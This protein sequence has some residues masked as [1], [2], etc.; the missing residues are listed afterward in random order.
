MQDKFERSFVFRFLNWICPEHLVEEIE[1]D[2]IQKFNSDVEKFD[3]KRA[4]RRL[5]WNV[6]RFC[7]LGIVLRS[8]L[9]LDVNHLYMI[10]IYIILV[11]RHLIRNKV[12]SLVNL[13]GLSVSMAVCILILQYVRFEVSYDDFHRQ[14]ENIY[15]VA[16]KVTLQG[17]VINHETNTYEGIS[18]ALVQDFPEVKAATSIRSFNS[19]GT[20]IRYE[21]DDKKLVPLQSFK[22]FDVDSTFFAVFSFQL[23]EGN[24][25]TVLRDPY[26]AVISEA[27]SNQ[28]FSGNAVGQVLEVYD[29]IETTRYKITGVLKDVP[30]NSHFKFDLLTRSQPRDKNFWNGD[31]GFWEWGGHSYILLTDQSNR[32]ALESKLAK[33]ALSK[34]ELKN[35]KDD[36]GQVSTFELQP[37]LDIHLFSHL[38]EELEANGSGVFVYSLVVLAFMIIIIAWVNYINL[39]T[40]VSQEKIRSIGVRKVVGASKSGLM[41]QVL[42]EA[43]VFNV[44]SVAIAIVLVHLLLPFFSNFSGIPLDYETLYDKWV[45]VFILAFIFVST[46]LSGLYPA[47]VIASFYPVRALKGSVNSGNSFSL[48]KALVVFQFAAAVMLMIVTGVAYQQL[49]FMRTKELGMAIDRVVII[50]ALNFD[51]ETWSDAEGGFTLDSAYLNKSNVFKEEIRSHV[52]FINATSLSHLPGQLPNWGTE[53]KAPAVDAEKAYRLLAVGIDY[54]FLSTFRV[55]LLAGRNFSPAFPSDRGNEGKRAVIINEAASK[56]LGFKTPEE[57]VHKHIAA[58]WGADYEIIGVVNSFHQLSLKDNLQPLYFILQPR[59]LSYYAVNYNGQN[60]AKAIEQLRAIWKQHFPDYPFNYFFLDQYFDKQ[61]QY[62]QTFTDII[63]L[64]ACLTIFIAC[65]GLFG[66]TSYAIAQRTKE[67]GIR[68]VLGATVTNVI[69]LFTRDFIKLILIANVVG[70]PIV[71]FGISRWLENYAFKIE[72]G[73]WFFAIPLILI[74]LIALATVSL[75]TIKVGM[76]NPVDSLRNE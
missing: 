37:L 2:L 1:G 20:F 52:G 21:D 36:Y 34:N 73:W 25:Q 71:Y 19:D 44:L 45:V 16:T 61:Y 12:F 66:L 17:E 14:A 10:R 31:V 75:Q 5:I 63:S 40:A 57:A 55:K 35:N 70:I 22:A 30:P 48:R 69:G 65:L 11:G 58:Y 68:K 47:F 59:A 76:Q 4:K 15:R 32:A 67:I 38:Q 64:F 43:G 60:A 26:S 46:L 28:C 51:K 23:L 8:Q 3:K 27:L 24:R 42:T 41:V 33:L 50:K 56:L 6:I 18:K 7:R 72:L 39:S 62:D 29:G 74:L 13:L 54:D 9:S 53:F 49:S